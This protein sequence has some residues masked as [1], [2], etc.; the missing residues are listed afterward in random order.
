MEE[1]KGTIEQMHEAQM[2]AVCLDHERNM[3]FGCG[4]CVCDGVRKEERRR[5]VFMPRAKALF[6]VQCAT[7]PH[8]RL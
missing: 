3:A 6:G 4:H 7:C 5:G 8:T 2:C 1:L